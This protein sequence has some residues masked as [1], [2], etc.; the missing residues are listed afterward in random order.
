MP[1]MVWRTM[2]EKAYCK[3]CLPAQIRVET[4]DACVVI[5]SGLPCLATACSLRVAK[6]VR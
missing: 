2:N 4:V 1:R 6:W 3:M 5:A